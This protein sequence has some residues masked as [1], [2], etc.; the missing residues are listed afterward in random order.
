MNCSSKPSV[1]LIFVFHFLIKTQ[2]K[3]LLF[4]KQYESEY[5]GYKLLQLDIQQNMFSLSYC[6][7][8]GTLSSSLDMSWSM[9]MLNK[10]AFVICLPGKDGV[11]VGWP[12]QEL[13]TASRPKTI[14][15]CRTF[16]RFLLW[17]NWNLSD[18][19]HSACN[20]H[21]NDW[22]F[23]EHCLSNIT[24]ANLCLLHFC[25]EPR[26]SG[27]FVS[28][29]ISPLSF[30]H[31]QTVPFSRHCIGLCDKPFKHSIKEGHHC[32]HAQTTSVLK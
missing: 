30:T 16:L 29:S 26:L 32:K 9:A 5:T 13:T 14:I 25:V 19:N 7:N 17:H 31:Q 24:R 10:T 6:K 23:C 8:S 21:E 3:L 18:L 11:G 22:K 1:L 15:L 12:M 4:P 27:C 20:R 28:G 2:L